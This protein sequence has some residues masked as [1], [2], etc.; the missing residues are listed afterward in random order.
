MGR[1]A[2]KLVVS[3]CVLCGCLF[4]AGSATAAA[5]V[6]SGTF[7]LASEIDSNNKIVAGPDGNVWL[8]VG[9]GNDVAKVTPTGQVEEFD[10]SEISGTN[11]I[12]V[13]PDGNLWVP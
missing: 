1:T 13:G 4:A 9:G 8:T 10:L 7:P 5:P 6:V 12:A 11:G 2:A 3:L